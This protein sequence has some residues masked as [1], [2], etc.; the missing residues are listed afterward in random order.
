MSTVNKTLESRGSKYDRVE[1]VEQSK[2]QVKG[3]LE[4]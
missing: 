2:D 3:M 1:D 4:S